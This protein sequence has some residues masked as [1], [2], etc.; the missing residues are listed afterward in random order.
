[1]INIQRMSDG[2]STEGKQLLFI[3]TVGVS[4]FMILYYRNQLKLGKMKMEEMKISK[5]EAKLSHE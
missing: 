5:D 1:M 2:Q 4:V 3:L